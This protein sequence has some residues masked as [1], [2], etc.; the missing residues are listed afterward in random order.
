MSLDDLAKLTAF[1]V[2]LEDLC[3]ERGIGFMDDIPAPMEGC[4]GWTVLI[5][6]EVGRPKSPPDLGVKVSDGIGAEDIVR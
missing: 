3:K 6:L 4:G 2:D 5:R 1:I